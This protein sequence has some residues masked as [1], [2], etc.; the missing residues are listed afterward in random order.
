L[1]KKLTGKNAIVTRE[2][3]MR[4]SSPLVKETYREGGACDKRN[5]NEMEFTAGLR[6]TP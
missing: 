4:W 2:I 1:F 5:N 3:I 6:I